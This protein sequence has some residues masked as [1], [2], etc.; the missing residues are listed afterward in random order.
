ML[1]LIK[2]TSFRY[3]LMFAISLAAL[4]SSGCSP[5]APEII[6]VSGNLML[7]GKP[8]PN[9]EVKFIPMVDGL[10]GN[11]IGSGVTDKDGNFTLT[12][13]GKTESGCCAC[14]CKI[15]INEGPMPDGI[16]GGENEQMAATKFLKSLKNRPIPTRF[17]RIA[18]TPLSVTV[19]KD[20]DFNMKLSR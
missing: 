18:D 4:I 8:L 2:I 19:S 17:N 10:D 14:D 3:V 7:D 13:P 1:R 20:Q 12:L 16:R 11:M 15:T 5:T 9:V 6:P